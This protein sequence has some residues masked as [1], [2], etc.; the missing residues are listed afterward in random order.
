MDIE[1]NSEDLKNPLSLSVSKFNLKW[2]HTHLFKMNKVVHATRQVSWVVLQESEH[3][4]GCVVYHFMAC[5]CLC[6]CTRAG[7]GRIQVQGEV[8]PAEDDMCQ[9]G[10]RWPPWPL[11]GGCGWYGK[12]GKRN[13]YT[14]CQKKHYFMFSS[15]NVCVWISVLQEFANCNS[16]VDVA[17]WRHEVPIDNVD[18]VCEEGEL[19]VSFLC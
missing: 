5:V 13:V 15:F 9:S 12:L 8:W 6:R 4:E 7:G 14:H 16:T 10:S 17:P 3:W 18:L 2:N 19:V 1:T 11:R